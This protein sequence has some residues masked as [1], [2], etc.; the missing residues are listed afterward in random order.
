MFYGKIVGLSFILPRLLST[1]TGSERFQIR[2]LLFGSAPAEFHV[3]ARVAV[4]VP[5]TVAGNGP[6]YHIRLFAGAFSNASLNR[7]HASTDYV[8]DVS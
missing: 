3:F 2:K 7:V 1:G 6:N 8:E 5:G 4:V